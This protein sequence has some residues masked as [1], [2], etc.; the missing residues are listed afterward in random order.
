[1]YTPGEILSS[2]SLKRRVAS[3]PLSCF[4]FQSPLFDSPI[5]HIIL[6]GG[7][8]V[9]IN[10][11]TYPML[12]ISPGGLKVVSLCIVDGLLLHGGLL[13]REWGSNI[14]RVGQFD[15][16]IIARVGQFFVFLRKVYYI[17]LAKIMLWQQ[18]W[19]INSLSSS[20]TKSGS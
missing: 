16:F 19:M 20:S 14:A 6:V 2:R 11:P 13:L 15:F 10:L 18:L 7:E 9:R 17:C 4:L 1:M 3:P 8:C 12:F 5:F